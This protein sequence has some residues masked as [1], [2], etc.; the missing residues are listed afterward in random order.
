MEQRVLTRLRKDFQI[1]S[2][3]WNDV[4]VTRQRIRWTKDTQ[5][6]PYIEVSQSKA[7]NELEEIRVERNTKEDFHCTPSMH[8]MYRSLLAQINWLQSRTQFQCCYKISRCASMAVS[9][10]S[11]DVKSL[12][13]LA[14][15]INSHPSML[16]YWPLTGPLRIRGF[17]D[18]FY[19][20]NDDGTSQRGLTVFLAQS[21]ERSSKDGM[22]Y[23]SLVDYA[24]K[25][26]RKIVLPTTV[27]KLYSF[28]QCFGSC[29]FLRGLWMDLSGEVG[30]T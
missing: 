27:A 21:R 3:D 8:T 16:Q 14:R 28:A 22:S 23:G 25:K 2:D 4:T 30:C 10:T 5:N 9:S 17:P 26:L 6:G 7:I 15:Q 19:R 11:G 29:Q 1:S 20:N 18:V 12:N 24:S 13:K